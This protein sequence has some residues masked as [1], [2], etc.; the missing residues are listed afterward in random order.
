MN[1]FTRILRTI[2]RPFQQETRNGCLD[3]VVING[4]GNYVKLW[5]EKAR[6]LSLDNSEEKTVDNLARRFANYDRLPPTDRLKIIESATAEIDALVSDRSSDSPQSSACRGRQPQWREPTEA[7]HPSPPASHAPTTPS[8][9]PSVPPPKPRPPRF[10]NP[11]PNIEVT[12]ADTPVET[13]VRT[14]DFLATPLHEAKGIGTRRANKLIA[15]LEVHT[16]GDLLQYYP[17]DYIDRRSIREIYDVGRSGE[18]ETIQGRVVNHDKFTPARKGAK[19]V[20]KVMIFDGTGVAVLVNFGR[21]IGYLRRELTVGTS[22]VISG[23]FGRRNNEIQTTDYEFEILED[24]VAD[25]IHTGRIVAKYPLT[26]NLTQR[27]LRQWINSVLDEYGEL[28]PEILPLDIRQRQRLIDRRTA[29]AEIHRPATDSYRKAARKRLAFDEFFLLEL[30]LELRKKRWKTEEKG[31][32]F[33]VESRLLDQFIGSLPFRLTE[34]QKRVF[35]TIRADMED[36]HPMNRLLQGDVG[37]GKTIVAA[38]SLL[39]AIQSGYQGALMVPTEILAEQHA[40]NFTELLKPI[41]LNVVLLKGDLTKNERETV[42]GDI[43]DGTAHIVV[44]TH[45]LIQKGVEFRRL[46]LVIIDE[47]HRFG[48]MQRAILRDKGITPDVLVM[49]ATPI[50]RTLAMTVYGDLNVSVIDEMP[51]GRQTIGT[52]W[53]REGERNEFYRGIEKTVRRGRQA[54]IVYPLVEESEKLEEIKAATEMANRLQCE[55]FP[56]LRLGLLHGRMRSSEKQEVMS[57]FKAKRIDILVSTT[58]I[59]VGIDVPN[60]TI[61]VIENAERFGLAQLHQL[62]GRVGRGEHRSFCY[63]VAAAKSQD[64]VERM[65]VMTRTNDGF[66]IAEADLQLRGPG[67]F[68]GTRQSGLPNLRLANLIQD[69]PLLE[70]AKTEANRLAEADPGL[71]QP[72]HQLLKRLLRTHWKEN[73][74]LATVG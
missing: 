13:D 57:Q 10:Q 22:V 61:M 38:M 56:D 67:E 55:V 8:E 71:R 41:G 29:T 60:A 24:E 43:A 59:E 70:A 15:E 52:K 44:G 53:V 36:A 73:L 72:G 63:L 27:M 4:L 35:K 62:R 54:Y 28:C 20:G 2:R 14:L 66:E 21:R 42:L 48:V 1:E 5:L 26:A 3:N 58:V 69:A 31:I 34:A 18:P 7:T 49:T 47:Q 25:L 46:G 6:Q 17:R 33:K 51:P 32:S 23:K 45:A 11:L 40:F 64:S 16:V 50:P 19:T 9:E 37:S 39:C 74:E 65:Q 12:I 68:F 30:G